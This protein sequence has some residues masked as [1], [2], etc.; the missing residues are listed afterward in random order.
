MFIKDM[1]RHAKFGK[2]LGKR[3]PQ[4]TGRPTLYKKS[5]VEQTRNLVMMGYTHKKIAEFY[6]IGETTLYVWKRNYGDFRQALDTCKD[7]YDSMVVRSLLD[8]ATGY[9]YVEKKKEIESG[10]LNDD[11]KPKT[12]TTRTKRHMP[13]NI[14][15]VK[16]WLY[17]RRPEEF[18]PEAALS[19]GGGDGMGP[20]PPLVINYNINPP[21]KGVKVTTSDD[22]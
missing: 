22:E 14:G 18:K 12:K 17:N 19:G 1:K 21:V 11:K 7:D 20:A 4:I 2:T 13:P 8:M 16:L 10:G 6:N 9:D 5:M 3:N 15:A